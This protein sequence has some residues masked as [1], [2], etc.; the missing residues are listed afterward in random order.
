MTRISRRTVLIGSGSLAALLSSPSWLR[1][2]ETAPKS[3]RAIQPWEFKS[4]QPAESGFV[5][6]R[7][8]IAEG[9]TAL[10]PDGNVVPCLATGWTTS[11]DAKKWRF[12]LRQGAVFH[13]GT[14]VTSQTV[15]A[16]LEALI[17][18]ARRLSAVPIS[19]IEA[20]EDE[21]VFHLDQPF[22]PLPAYLCDFAI[23][24]Y[25][26]AA[27]GPDGKVARIIATG[28][29]KVDAIELPRRL[30]LV[31]HENYWG[32]KPHVER[33]EFEAVANGET[34]T[35]MALAGD[36]DVIMN[37]PTPS[38]SRIA[39]SGTMQVHEV[40]NPRVH[41]LYPDCG[42]PQFQD[43]R[44]RRA[45]S[46][47]I[48]RTA[49]A[50]TIMR[51]ADLAA[52]QLFPPVMPDWHFDD[53]P[54]YDYDV[55][56]AEALLDEAGWVKGADGIRSKDGVRFAGTIRTFPNRPEMP[57]IA[58]ALQAMFK[59]VGYELD[60]SIGEAS[61][62]VEAK[63]SGNLDIGFSSRHLA[64]VPDGIAVISSE[65][66]VEDSRNQSDTGATNWRNAEF[67][68]L[69]DAYYGET[70]ETVRAKSRRRLAE[71]LQED[72]PVLPI[73]WYSQI[74]AVSNQ[75]QG[76]VND[77]FEQRLYLDQ[78]SFKG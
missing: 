42:K 57:V 44:T 72:V 75:L 19:Y 23:S 17:P 13:D 15:K 41:A 37:I 69:C 16:S 52:T 58:A 22:G 73:V 74:F 66:V 32:R 29:Y 56:A 2:Q 47:A 49:I 59:T 8:S 35:N 14:P 28:P 78:L 21:I 43:V 4:I 20:E 3:I 11:D 62:I 12:A 30:S 6:N 70:D 48:D 61:A 26:P 38:I 40:I 10:Q 24:V 39:N 53:L 64:I 34:R 33:A 76:F 63:Q 60:I 27:F 31:R 50:A 9:L 68:A 51:N 1:A 36:A 67:D 77:P 18:E 71:I 7:A 46:L 45:L 54:N 65:F 5:L 25:A 55:A